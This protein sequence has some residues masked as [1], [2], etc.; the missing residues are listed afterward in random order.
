[1][2]IKKLMEEI[3]AHEKALMELRKSYT[4]LDKSE[5]RIISFDVYMTSEVHVYKG[6]ENLAKEAGEEI[7]ISDFTEERVK[8][9]FKHNDITYFQLNDKAGQ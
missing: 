3:E 7:E 1:M 2:E 4:D 8:L 5:V 9:E 6:I